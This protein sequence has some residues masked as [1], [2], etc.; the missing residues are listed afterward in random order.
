MGNLKLA[1]F[2][3]YKS[4]LKGSRWTLILVILVVSLSFSN[5]ILTPSIMN[6]VA[7]SINQEQIN[8]LFG[9]II[10]DPQ[11]EKN[12]LDN[13]SQIEDEV[14]RI[15]GITGVAPHLNSNASF[16]Y[17][18]QQ[19]DSSPEKN[20]SGTWSVI[21]IYPEKETRVT[22]IHK[23]LISGD[24][25]SPEDTNKIVLG[26]EIAGGDQADNKDFLTL[27]GVKVGQTIR[28]TF[29]NNIQRDYQVKGIFK[30]RGGG[31][32]NLAFVTSREMASVFSPSITTENA[33]QILIRTQPGTDQ[34]K[35]IAQLK[36]LGIDGQVRS[37]E[38]YGGG[39]GGIISSFGIVASLIGGIGLLVA[40]VVMFIVIYINVANRKRQIGILRAIGIN[41]K[42]VL[43]SYLTQALLYAAAG[44][45]FGGLIFGYI[46]KP[47]FDSHPIDLPIGLVSLAIDMSTIRNAILGLF[48]AAVLAG[49]IPVLNITRH[50]IIKAIWG[51]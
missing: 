39:I 46:I 36:T 27:G 3:A 47:F 29:P 18:W 34:A 33:N 41:R 44:I 49:I 35:L 19:S 32:S 1:L 38:D 21:G 40:G 37:W 16:E 42:V 26:V 12:Y 13:V 15:P 14:A 24:Y 31:A 6:G 51:A 2:L 10:I 48:V 30:A 5:L 8:T 50:S 7:D 45:I 23:S 28:L 4:I 17:N 11:S 22:T 9:N 43:I 20:T 25:L